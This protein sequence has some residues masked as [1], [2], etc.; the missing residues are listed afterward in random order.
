MSGEVVDAYSPRPGVMRVKYADGRCEELRGVVCTGLALGPGAPDRAEVPMA[1]TA[2]A[3]AARHARACA[4][5]RATTRRMRGVPTVGTQVDRSL[6]D[7]ED[8]F[9]RAMMRFQAE[10]GVKFP[11]LSQH[12]YVLKELGYG[13]VGAPGPTATPA[14]GDEHATHE[15]IRALRSLG[16]EWA[17]IRRAMRC[18]MGTIGEA[19][20]G[21]EAGEGG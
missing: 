6:E 10:K 8:E 19:L 3:R 5:A 4:N 18:G 11:T 15:A 14:G 9:V 13:K 20:A 7:D 12:L 17:R 16:W 2:E 1:E 21:R